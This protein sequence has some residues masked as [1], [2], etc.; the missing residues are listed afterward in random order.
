MCEIITKS[1]LLGCKSGFAGI[2]A[3]SFMP[4]TKLTLTAGDMF[5]GTGMTGSVYRY[6]LKNDGCNY[7]ETGASDRNTSTTVYD[8]KLSLVL[9]VLDRAT[10]DEIK[11]MAYGRPLIF[12][13]LFNGDIWLLGSE[14]GCELNSVKMGSG[15]ARKDMS[16]FSLEF[17]TQE[18]RPLVFL[19][20]TGSTAYNAAIMTTS[21][22][23]I[24]PNY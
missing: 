2:K 20:A 14:F 15:G 13:E 10:R 17:S 9:P 21:V 22:N 12:A 16:G 11:L 8:G 7:E 24:K 4:Y 5:E 19:G 18:R 6:E 1:R 3:V 23:V